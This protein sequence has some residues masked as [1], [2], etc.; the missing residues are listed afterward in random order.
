MDKVLRNVINKV[1]ELK[2]LNV[3]EVFGLDLD[4][5]PEFKGLDKRVN[6]IL[7]SLKPKV[8]P[9]VYKSVIDIV[10]YKDRQAILYMNFYFKKGVIEGL[11]DLNFLSE[12]KDIA[13]IDSFGGNKD[14]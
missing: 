13:Y 11:T 1:I 9:D 10:E 14:D 2:K 5:S 7:E 4:K 12:I 6:N 3:S 8:S